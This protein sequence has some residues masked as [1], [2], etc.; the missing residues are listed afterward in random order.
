MP[1]GLLIIPMIGRT[2]RQVSWAQERSNNDAQKS[3]YTQFSKF[4][5]ILSKN[6]KKTQMRVVAYSQLS[7]YSTRHFLS[8]ALAIKPNANEIYT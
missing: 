3:A 4:S 1:V 5:M 6:G 7:L 2:C 8:F